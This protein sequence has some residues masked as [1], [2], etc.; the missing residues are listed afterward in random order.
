LADESLLASV[1]RSFDESQG[2]FGIPAC[3]AIYM[4]KAFSAEKSAWLAFA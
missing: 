4:K 2:I 1:K 3:I